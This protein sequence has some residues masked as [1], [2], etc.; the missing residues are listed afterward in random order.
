M[1]QVG[2]L[3]SEEYKQIVWLA[4]YPKSGNTWVRLFMDAYFMGEVNINEIV[5]SIGDDIALRH[6]IGDDSRVQDLPI[7]I[8]QLT[9]PMSLLRLVHNYVKSRINIPL[10]VKTHASHAVT[11][12][13]EQLPECLTKATVF[14]VRDPRDVLPSYANHMGAESLDEALVWMDEQYRALKATETKMMDFISSWG[15]HTKSFLNADTHNVMVVKYEDLRRDPLTCFGNILLHAGV[16]P[17]IKRIERP[18][19]YAI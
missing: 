1:Y 12:G 5:S 8:Q 15:F 4:S 6:S 9:R 19:S 11:N 3:N 13:I 10:L 18:S 2:H 7:Q 14:L 16:D 17:D